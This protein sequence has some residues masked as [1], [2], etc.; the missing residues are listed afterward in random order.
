M[1]RSANRL[2][3]VTTNLDGFSLANHGRF[4]KFTKLSPRQTFPLYGIT[5]VYID[6]TAHNKMVKDFYFVDY[7]D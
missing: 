1:N 4:A 3:V 2:S 7:C 6:N 5:T